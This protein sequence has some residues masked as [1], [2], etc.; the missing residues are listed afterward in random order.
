MN[1]ER[2]KNID[3]ILDVALELDLNKRAAFLDEAC[4]GD[5]D[6]RIEVEKL[7]AADEQANSMIEGSALNEAAQF[8]DTVETS[9]LTPG[10]SIGPYKI[11]SLLGSGGMGEVY[12]ARDYRLERDVAIKVLPEDVARNSH[13]IVRF[14]REMKALAAL[15]HPNIITIYDVGEQN[16]IYYAV[17]ELLR[18]ETL[19]SYL[20][21]TKCTWDR[22]VSIGAS[23]AEGLAAAHSQGVTHRDLKPENIFLTSDGG[24]KIL[25]FGLVHRKPISTVDESTLQIRE[26]EITQ[27]GILMGTLPYM[28]PEQIRGLPT[29]SRSDL[30]SVGTILYEM[31]SGK[32]PFYG[33][34]TA[35]LTASI[36]KEEPSS[37]K[38]TCPPVLIQTIAQCLRKMPEERIQSAGE[39]ANKL[40]TISGGTLISASHVSIYPAR[41]LQWIILTS[42][43]FVIA[44][45]ISY[46][47]F[48][49][50]NNSISSI[51]VLPLLDTKHDS[52][53]EYLSDGITENIID[54]LTQIH[55]LRVMRGSGVVYKGKEIEPR[56]VGRELNVEAVVTGRILRKD[57]NLIISVDLVKVS[58]GSLLWTKQYN[59]NV[60]DLLIIQSDISRELFNKINIPMTGKQ[61][62]IVIKR[63]TDDPEAYQF[64]LRARYHWMKD[65]PD[66]YKIA[67]EYF[68]KAIEK[69]PAYARAYIALAGYYVSLGNAGFE[70]PAEEWSQWHDAMNHAKQLDPQLV[71][72]HMGDAEYQFFHEWNW[73]SAESALKRGL[74]LSPGDPDLHHF[75]GLFLRAMERWDE[76]IAEDKES[77][78]L[79]PLS[80]LVNKS[81]G[82]AYFWAKRYDEALEQFKKTE[83]LD[84]KYAGIHDSMADV[85]SR[86]GMFE[87]SIAEME[88]YLRLSGYGDLADI[89]RSKYQE[90]G[91]KAAIQT[92]YENQLDILN[93]NTPEGYVSPIAFAIVYSQLN[94]K[95]QA[96]E[97]LEKAYQERSSWLVFLK[98]DPQFDNLRS[99]P[100]LA[101]LIRRIGFPK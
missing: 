83:E 46:F 55:D 32:R 6:L 67:H 54:T 82:T 40:R 43:L 29:D 81:V 49:W 37:M 59:R 35:D 71:E 95:D 87:E 2:W 94:R 5:K 10:E 20:S 4:A 45:L 47:Y 24:I 23:I 74:Q 17:M 16:G 101:S 78:E 28:S 72:A 57:K 75:Y 79:D 86:K 93:Q 64:F 85:Y 39:L 13:A 84:P 15:S 41:K 76:A 34:T 53:T 21:R 52:D 65:T 11:L 80:I 98:T 63:Y 31:I 61:Q 18:G 22:A 30:F 26:S 70:P 51:A 92:L 8:L 96:F 69:D 44:A 73:S 36:L 56:T 68:Q 97:W 88:K 33:K 77:Q 9:R 58:D 50:T 19:R 91:Y 60:S 66:D 100:R 12:R 62:E 3:E 89:F 42:I 38:V 25:D 99:D 7:L 48:A 1:P 90:S 14:E 27:A